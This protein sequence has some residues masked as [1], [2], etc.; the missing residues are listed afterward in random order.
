MRIEL[1]T[2]IPLVSEP[3]PFQAACGFTAEDYAQVLADLLPRGWAWPRDPETVLMRVFGG[4]AV[5]FSRVHGRDCDLLAES[6]PGT[7]IEALT[8]WERITGL[9]D[10]CL[11]FPLNSLQARRRA[12]LFKLAAR[13]GASK[14]Y[15]I[16]IAGLLGFPITITEF[17]PFRAGR[18]R[19]GDRLYNQDWAYA[20]RVNAPEVN[21]FYFRSGQSTA[22][23]RLRDWG[24]AVLECILTRL[25]PAH[26]ILH[27]GYGA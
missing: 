8:D 13:G 3:P 11:P 22:S 24:N 12:V 14:A 9:P 10:P 15:F 5:E 1:D 26:T 7:A 17:A 27:F 20:W 21:I 18:N 2:I 6:Y 25:K 23:E 4:L 16:W 19:T